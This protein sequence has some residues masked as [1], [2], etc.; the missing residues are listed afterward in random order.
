MLNLPADLEAILKGVLNRLGSTSLR[1]SYRR[2]ASQIF[3]QAGDAS[4]SNEQFEESLKRL[5]EIHLLCQYSWTTAA[6]DLQGSGRVK[7]LLDTN[8]LLRLAVCHTLLTMTL[9]RQFTRFDNAVITRHRPPNPL[10]VLGCCDSPN[11][12]EWTRSHSG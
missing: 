2:Y 3:D 11:C 5:R 8:I 9:S 10:R 12:T 1:M 7:V 6:I 4:I